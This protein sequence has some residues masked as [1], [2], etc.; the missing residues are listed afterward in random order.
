M[1]TWNDPELQKKQEMKSMASEVFVMVNKS[2]K[3]TLVTPKKK[4]ILCA[5]LDSFD[6]LVGTE[7]DKVVESRKDKR[8][9]KKNKGI[10]EEPPVHK[11]I[12]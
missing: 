3:K 1:D 4:N 8:N 6:A 12:A 5:P 11:D 10:P 9:R 7:E 2:E